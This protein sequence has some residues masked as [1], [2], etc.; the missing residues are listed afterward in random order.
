MSQKYT[1]DKTDTYKIL[2]VV[3]Y[4]GGA[5]ALVALLNILPDVEFPIMVAWAVPI[6]NVFLVAAVKFFKSKQ[7]QE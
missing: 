2:K 7:E 6:V 1:F 5:G 4:A 3:F